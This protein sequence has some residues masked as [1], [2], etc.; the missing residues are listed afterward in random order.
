MFQL[1]EQLPEHVEVL[2]TRLVRLWPFAQQRTR[3]NAAVAAELKTENTT[4]LLEFLNDFWMR[5]ILPLK[6]EVQPSEHSER[7]QYPSDPGMVWFEDVKPD[8]EFYRKGLTTEIY[9]K[10]LPTATTC[11]RL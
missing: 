7:P 2:H 3:G 5:S 9:E 6:G 10:D 8:A 1:L 4:A 11:V